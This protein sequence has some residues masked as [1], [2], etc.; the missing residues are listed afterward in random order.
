VEIISDGIIEKKTAVANNLCTAA[1]KGIRIT[2]K[3]TKNVGMPARH[4][5]HKKYVRF[6]ELKDNV[7]E[8]F[9]VGITTTIMV[10]AENSN[11]RAVRETKTDS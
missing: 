3:Q 6:Q 11:I 10:F 9:R 1:V 8:T 7:W 5:H 4:K 2:F